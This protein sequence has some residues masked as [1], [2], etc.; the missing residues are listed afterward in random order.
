MG[1]ADRA[2]KI[3][4]A[5]EE[6]II[7]PHGNSMK[8]RVESGARVTLAPIKPQ[9]ICVGDVVLCRVKGRQY[10]HLVKKRDTNRFLIGNNKGKINGWIGPKAVYGKAI[11]IEN[12]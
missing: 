4:A 11:K 1:W 7:K 2:I 12:P 3:L 8:G 9:D 10:L 5:G 6:A